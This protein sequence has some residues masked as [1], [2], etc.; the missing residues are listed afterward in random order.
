MFGRYEYHVY[1]YSELAAL[2]QRLWDEIERGASQQYFFHYPRNLA[3][4]ARDG[5]TWKG[6]KP[7]GEW[8]KIVD[9]FP[10]SQREIE[11]GVDCFAMDDYPG[12]VFHMMRIAELG[13][14]AIARE[15]GVK[16]LSGK[17]GA[18]KPIE[19]GTWQEVFD[20]IEGELTAIRRATPGPKRDAA[21]SFYGTALSDLR[22][23]RD[24]YRDPT[25]HFRETY[26]QGQ[27]ASAMFRVQSLMR[28]LV[29]KLSEE[30]IRKIRWGL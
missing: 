28:T 13:L 7:G 30:K 2:L 17:R 26:D 22:T 25:M 5:V 1:K 21:L 23:L 14:R 16:S 9:A 20:A 24:L 4:L 8:N 29:S 11:S 15:R 18:R 12:S 6:G 3:P 10:S 19:W 27:A